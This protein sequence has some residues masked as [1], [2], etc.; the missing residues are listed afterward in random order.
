MRYSVEH[1]LGSF[2]PSG[3]AWLVAACVEMGYDFNSE[4]RVVVG[5]IMQELATGADLR[6]LVQLAAAAA[7]GGL[8]DQGALVEGL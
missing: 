8:L 2:T 5:G 7:K 4:Q 3:F 1:L 6:G